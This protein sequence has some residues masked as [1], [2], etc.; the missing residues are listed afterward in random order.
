MK[1]REAGRVSQD[2][3]ADEGREDRFEAGAGW[4]S[5]ARVD[6]RFTGRGGRLCQLLARGDSE[7]NWRM[8][9]R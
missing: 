7:G 9:C 4:G 6:V 3:C 8:L 2:R 5:D 1:G